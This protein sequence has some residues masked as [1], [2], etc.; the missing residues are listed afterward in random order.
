MNKVKNFL[1]KYFSVF[2]IINSDEYDEHISWVYPKDFEYPDYDYTDMSYFEKQQILLNIKPHLHIGIVGDMVYFNFNTKKTN[3]YSHLQ[4]I[5]INK[6]TNDDKSTN[7]EVI[8]YIKSY[9]IQFNE[10]KQTI[11]KEKLKKINDNI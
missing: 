7:D 6:R 11:R 9:M 1:N 4:V 2:K 8:N 5:D 10:Y 3:L